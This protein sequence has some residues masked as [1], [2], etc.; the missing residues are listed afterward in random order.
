M[1]RM[2]ARV[3]APGVEP[4][5]PD[6]LDGVP[7]G[8]AYINGARVGHLTAARVVDG[9]L[10]IEY[11][12]EIDD[13]DALAEALAPRV[14]GVPMRAPHAARCENPHHDPTVS[15]CSTP[16]PTFRSGPGRVY[17]LASIADVT[18]PT[19]AELAAGM[20]ITAAV[21]PFG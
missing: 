12:V 17:V 14:E 7:L 18:A 3:P 19:A 11:E 8:P 21:E 15:L 20:E 13:G 5:A 6:A 16:P 9:G 4:L 1:T 10:W 2:T